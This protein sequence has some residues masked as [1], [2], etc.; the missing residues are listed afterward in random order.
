MRWAERLRLE[1]VGT[2]GNHCDRVRGRA[3]TTRSLMRS[4]Q[5]VDQPEPVS[6]EIS[7]TEWI[8][9]RSCA[10]E[11]PIAAGEERIV[12]PVIVLLHGAFAESSSWNGVIDRL[13]EAGYCTIAA[14]NPLRGISS[15]AQ[16][17]ADIVTSVD[18]PVVL[19]GHSYGGAV[20][21]NV[22]RGAGD[23]RSLVYVAGFAP[24]RGE[25]C[26]DLAGKVPGGTLGDTLELVDLTGPPP[27]GRDMYIAQHKYHSQFC[28]DLPEQRALQMA[29]T[30]R[31]VTEAAL[32]EPSASAPLWAVVPSWFIYGELDRNI[33]ARSHAFMAERAQAR[34]TTEV[35]GA[36]HVVAISHPAEVAAMILDAA[37]GAFA[38]A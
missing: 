4:C 24:E 14:A 16:A 22:P 37:A 18:G 9:Q 31:P 35:A 7:A 10:D 15:D 21:T 32:S 8:E 2:S 17:V 28:A 1:L 29:V 12:K 11:L 36:S 3:E 38:D 25:S 30:Q 20:I 26:G 34:S 23:I 33:P 6:K 27:G 5:A 19:V 13:H